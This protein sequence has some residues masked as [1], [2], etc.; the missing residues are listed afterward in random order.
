[1]AGMSGKA[2]VDIRQLPT[3]PRRAGLSMREAKPGSG[4]LMGVKRKHEPAIEKPRFGPGRKQ[5]R[6]RLDE[7]RDV[8]V[9]LDN[10][11]AHAPFDARRLIEP[12]GPVPRS[13]R[14]TPHSEH[15]RS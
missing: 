4:P 11:A 10:T 12:V 7:G 9:Y 14:R 2:K 15:A 13:P 6:R 3:P 5:P 1:M 8:H